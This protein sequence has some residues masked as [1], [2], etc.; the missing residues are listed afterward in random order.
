MPTGW[1]RSLL[2][3][4]YDCLGDKLEQC[5]KLYVTC[6]FLIGS[7]LSHSLSTVVSQSIAINEP[8]VYVSVNYRLSAW[9]FLGSKEMQIAAT[10]GQVALNAGLLD[11]VV[12][13]E[14][15]QDNIGAFGGDKNKVSLA[16]WSDESIILRI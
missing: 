15:V 13:L 6:Y 9:G 16:S 5:D 3:Y 8:I 7:N 12:A 2:T 10:K 11:I 14:W 1:R 4:G